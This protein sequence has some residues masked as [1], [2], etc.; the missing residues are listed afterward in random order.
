MQYVTIIAEFKLL[1]QTDRG[2]EVLLS[3]AEPTRKEKGCIDYTF[4][5]DNDDP[6]ILMLYENWETEEDLKAHTGTEGFKNT[7][8]SIEGLFELKVHKL[9]KIT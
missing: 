9:T 4:Y 3:L 2:K 8:K 7:F 5:R 1:E 6:N